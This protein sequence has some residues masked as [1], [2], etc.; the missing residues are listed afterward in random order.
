MNNYLELGVLAPGQTALCLFTNGQF[1]CNYADGTGSTGL[2][3][4]IEPA[5]QFTRI[6]IYKWTHR[7]GQ[8]HVDVLTAV[9]IGITGPEI[10]GNFGG[11]YTV[12]FRELHVA[13]TTEADWEDFVMTNERPVAYV[14]HGN[15]V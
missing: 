15:G 8:R 6:I 13:G 1:L 7:N 10:G 14:T 9:P 12:D 2:W 3:V 11:R 5:R 4:L